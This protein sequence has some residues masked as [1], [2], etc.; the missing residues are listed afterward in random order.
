MK[1]KTMTVHVVL[2]VSAVLM[3]IAGPT[4][5][6]Q[7]TPA[8]TAQAAGASQPATT[9][10]ETRVQI[11]ESVHLV[12]EYGPFTA[13][14][15][16]AATIE[17]NNATINKAIEQL[18]QAGG[19]TIRLPEG[20]FHI[21]PDPSKSDRAITIRYSNITLRGAGAARTILKT[22]GVWNRQHRRRGHGIVVDGKGPLANIALGDFELD[23]QDGWTGQYNWPASPETGAGW[24]I[25]HKG[26]AFIVGGNLDNVL[27]ENLY[28]HRYRGEMLYVAGMSVGKMTVRHVKVNDTNASCFNLYAADLLVENCEFGGPS[29]FWAELLSRPN[30][31]GFKANRMV[32]RNNKFWN[33]IDRKINAGQIAIC[34]GDFK[35]YSITFENNE[36]RDC[37]D[38]FGFYKGVAGP[39]TITGN[40]ITNC[41]K[42]VLFG[43]SGGWINSDM[44]A[45]ITVENN[46]VTHGISLVAFSSNRAEDVVL[47]NNKFAGK[48]GKQLGESVAVIVEDGARINRTRVENNTFTDCRMPEQA[49]RLV[50]ERPLFVKNTYTNAPTRQGQWVTTI[51]PAS[52]LVTPRCEEVKILTDADNTVAAL[53][54]AQYPDGQIITVTGG[55]RD[56]RVRFA[57]GQASYTVARDLTLDGRTT[58]YFS[59]DKANKKW[60]ETDRPK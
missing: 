46:T 2:A 20:T 1:R 17:Q 58:L 55:S 23:G 56:K 60:V 22:N 4:A 47:R 12:T 18:G 52:P 36:M 35:P 57:A 48:S 37:P 11:A 49:D 7:Q 43:R 34:Q 29:R 44:N 53:A 15:S 45:N 30:Q 14:K 42:M 10:Q 16:D 40:R 31:G 28:V 51:T 39:V 3:L 33:V 54:T 32:F 13:E 5:L 19:G 59:Y 8:G 24:D 6:G 50:G 38:V 41:G 25:M 26:I 21:G 9:G 27:L